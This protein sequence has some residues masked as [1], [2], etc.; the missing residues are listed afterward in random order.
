MTET[1]TTIP[2]GHI[3][4]ATRALLDHIDKHDLP[5]HKGIFPPGEF[6]R[7]NPHSILIEVGAHLDAWIESGILIDGEDN[8]DRRTPTGV[9]YVRTVLDARLPDQGI[10]VAIYGIAVQRQQ[11]SH[12]AAVQ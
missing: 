7:L 11:A 4:A 10:R 1:S 3:S 5:Q 9:N 12:L 8:D 2:T 6:G